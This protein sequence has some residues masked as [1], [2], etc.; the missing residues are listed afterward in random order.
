MPLIEVKGLKSYFYTE[1]GVVRAVDGVDFIIEPEKTLGIVGDR[2]RR[3]QPH[4]GRGTAWG[5][6]CPAPG[7]SGVPYGEYL[8][9]VARPSAP[10]ERSGSAPRLVEPRSCAAGTI[11]AR[12]GRRRTHQPRETLRW[13]GRRDWLVARRGARCCSA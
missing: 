7:A 8:P 13:S 4:A 10:V 3:C 1:R 5:V 2:R 9:T 6:F 11:P 12:A